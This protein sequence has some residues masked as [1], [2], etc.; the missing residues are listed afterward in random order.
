MKEV[1]AKSSN[2]ISFGI[3]GDTNLNGIIEIILSGTIFISVIVYSLYA[4]VAM[5]TIDVSLTLLFYF[6]PIFIA[7]M[8]F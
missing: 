2:E 7:C 1:W 8:A 3:V 5:V 6:G 4:A